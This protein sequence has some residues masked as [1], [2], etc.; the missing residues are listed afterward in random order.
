M[1]IPI[2]SKNPPESFPLATIL[3]I[4]INVVVFFCSSS[5]GL[6]IR[7]DVL[8]EWG[9]TGASFSAVHTLTSCF[10]HAD[11]LHLIGN[12]WFLYLFGFAVEGRLR[13]AKFVLLYFVAAFA[14]DLMHQ[15]VVAQFH[16]SVPSIGAS[17]AIMGVLGAA[18]YMFPF[19]H[20]EFLWGW[21]MRLSIV[22]WNVWHV[23]L[24]YLGLDLVL[25]LL[26]GG[27]T[28]VAHFAHLG[29]A[30]GG[31]IACAAFRARRD[32]M[33]AS[34][35]RAV[36]AD[37]KE[38]AYLSSADL[39]AM[40]DSAPSDPLIVL[41]WVRRGLRDVGGPSDRCKAAF[42]RLLPEIVELPEVETIGS[43]FAGLSLTPGTIPTRMLLKIS[44]K[45]ERYGEFSLALQLLDA[46]LRHP[47]Q[48]HSDWEAA[49][50]RSAILCETA[51]DNPDRA[52][53]TYNEILQRSPM[54]PIAEQARLRLAHLRRS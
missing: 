2:K 12:M 4:V 53:S 17:G 5:R 16:P 33:Q 21:G 51:L 28:G 35:A 6:E 30:L 11:L 43:V 48:T 29:G 9:Q 3:L 36:Y 37:T 32:S 42:Y 50:I 31:V 24:W 54:S 7:E 44:Y 13:T 18:L 8:R 52:R 1:L 19:G 39:A 25:A 20:V 38:L 40:N 22:I 26:Q 27:S 46:V 49:M 45:L 41:H 10:L 23:A 15:L 14:G 34:E 47:E